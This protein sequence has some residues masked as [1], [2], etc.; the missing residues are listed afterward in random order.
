M[1]FDVLMIKKCDKFGTCKYRD[2]DSVICN[3]EPFN[4]PLNKKSV[5]SKN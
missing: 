3:E 4:C 5:R 1:E 2:R